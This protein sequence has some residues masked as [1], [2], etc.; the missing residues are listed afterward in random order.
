MR[1]DDYGWLTAKLGELVTAERRAGIYASAVQTWIDRPLP[2]AAHIVRRYQRWASMRRLTR[3]LTYWQN[4]VVRISAVIH[5]WTAATAVLN[6][7]E[8]GPIIRTPDSR[9]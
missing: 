1:P 5:A 6:G 2:R 3:K 8:R 7:P 9:T 4:E